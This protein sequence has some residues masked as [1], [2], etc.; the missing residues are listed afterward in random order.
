[1]RGLRFVLTGLLAGLC[2]GCGLGDAFAQKIYWTDL[3][4]GKIQSAN[5][6]G[7]GVADVVS[8]LTLGSTRPA[9]ID[10]DSLRAR[11]YWTDFF[12]GI[13]RVS[14]DGTNAKTLFAVPSGRTDIQG[15][16]VDA[17]N[18]QIYWGPD[19]PFNSPL[20]PAQIRRS[21]LDFSAT[22]TL[23]SNAVDGFPGA[24]GLD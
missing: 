16:A 8:T 24:L 22:V 7:T 20:G 10:V 2:L 4:D 11:I 6:D 13:H 3:L 9:G 18:K 21:D 19:H 17:V 12:N 23:L 15:I 1:M 5:L 14:L